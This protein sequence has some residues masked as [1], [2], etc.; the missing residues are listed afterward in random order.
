MGKRKIRFKI[1]GYMKLKIVEINLKIDISKSIHSSEEV[2]DALKKYI[3]YLILGDSFYIVKAMRKL[4]EMGIVTLWD[5]FI[6]RQK[7]GK[8][9]N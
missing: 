3:H 6:E 5:I 8:H 2:K 9:E 4:I 7:R 1:E